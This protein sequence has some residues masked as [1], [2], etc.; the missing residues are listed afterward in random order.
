MV[1]CNGRFLSICVCSLDFVNYDV[2]HRRKEN[3]NAPQQQHIVGS[4]F[5]VDI[6]FL[7]LSYFVSFIMDNEFMAANNGN[8]LQRLQMY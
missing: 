1:L 5:C 8:H 2:K 3:K 4:L 6:L 7:F